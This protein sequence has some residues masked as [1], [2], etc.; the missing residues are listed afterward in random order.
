MSADEPP[1]LTARLRAQL[2]SAWAMRA[3][4]VTLEPL[5][6]LRHAEATALEA[7]ASD[8]VRYLAASA[9]N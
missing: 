7:D 5:R 4:V 2:L 1:L 9:S 3:G 8:V 6:R